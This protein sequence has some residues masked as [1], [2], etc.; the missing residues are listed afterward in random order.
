[1]A[2]S[3]N[4]F[5]CAADKFISSQRRFFGWPERCRSLSANVW[6]G[7]PNVAPGGSAAGGFGG[8]S[9]YCAKASDL[10]IPGPVDT[11]VFVDEHPDSIN[12]GA[13]F[14]PQSVAQ[15]VDIF[16]RLF[17]IWPVA[18]PLQMA[19]LKFINGGEHFEAGV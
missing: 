15:F 13:F 8:I 5:K 4:I 12:D 18:F 11:F 2:K 16:R 7:N 9:K 1:M 17:I 3:K 19:I 6:L 14:P 10:T